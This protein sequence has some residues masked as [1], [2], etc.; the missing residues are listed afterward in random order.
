MLGDNFTLLHRKSSQSK[1]EE[2]GPELIPRPWNFF[3]QSDFTL[4]QSL[5]VQNFGSSYT[6]SNR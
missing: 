5:P 6:F 4:N 2:D 3:E 1:Y